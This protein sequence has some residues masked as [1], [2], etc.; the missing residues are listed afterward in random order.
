ML[1]HVLLF[2]ST[3]SFVDSVSAAPADTPK[4]TLR[5][6]ID[7]ALAGN[8]ELAAS[9]Y[10]IEAQ[11]ARTRQA[12]LTPSIGLGV[13]AEN[14]LGTGDFDGVD[15]AELTLALSSVIELGGKADARI[16]AS[17]A[18]RDALDTER[19]VLQLDVLAEVARRFV[20]V[21]AAEQRL[22]VAK[23]SAELSAQTVAGAK[24]RVDAAKSPHVELD[25]AL[26]AM[27]RT[28]LEQGR[29]IAVLDSARRQL[30]ATWGN[31]A[32]AA[33]AKLENGV[34]ADLFAMPVV[35]DFA[36]LRERLTASP[37]FLRFAS[38]SRVRAAE[39]RVATT[40]QRPDVTV[41]IGIRHL[42]SPDDQAFVG[43][44][45]IPLASARRAD[46]H[47]AEARAKLALTDAER[48]V[49]ETKASATL[50]ELVRLL[51]QAVLE[52]DTL[53]SDVAPRSEE[54]LRETGYAYERGR[55]SYLELV[56]AQR[57]YLSVQDAL[58]AS[59]TDAH[60]LQIEVERLTNASLAAPEERR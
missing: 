28:R 40:L 17:R 55:Y 12:A 22:D 20:D 32:A 35:G 36:A 9:A 7:A 19:M 58:I 42:Q 27:D 15:E 3:I 18:S 48:R 60:K 23:R 16:A 8:P 14:L 54:A 34:Y 41:G 44:I 1:R 29:A 39:L 56:D 46:G 37:D 24:R 25:R 59:A 11:D 38:E 10:E 52:V 2:C 33:E 57:E 4:L 30:T 53:K 6:A 43:S 51:E 49:A 5:E 13:E 21:A 50:Y 26:I 47:I 45:S 31:A